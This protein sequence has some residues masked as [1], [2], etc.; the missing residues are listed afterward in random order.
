ML[1]SML[2]IFVVF[3]IA[4]LAHPALGGDMQ[5]RSIWVN[6]GDTENSFML[7]QPYPGPQ[8]PFY[9][10]ARGGQAPLPDEDQELG[11]S[12]GGVRMEVDDELC[13][14]LQRRVDRCDLAIEPDQVLI[15]SR[16][17]TGRMKVRLRL[18]VR[19]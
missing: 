3:V 14:R 15:Y 11:F 8:T 18:G 7:D 12:L 9:R 5:L 6:G 1:S 19:P 2:V 13:I 16:E 17:S 4:F 10:S